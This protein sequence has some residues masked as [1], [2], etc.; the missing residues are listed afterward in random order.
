M[1]PVCAWPLTLAAATGIAAPAATM[2]HR[3]STMPAPSDPDYVYDPENW[4][5]TFEFADRDLATEDCLY[6]EP[7]K[8][9]STLV[10][11]PDIWA[12]RD[13]NGRA[14]WFST[15]EDAERFRAQAKAQEEAEEDAA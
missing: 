14:A 5:S 7:V 8:R 2:R 12:A 11:G 13:A 10:K 1:T 4:E 6:D 15:K 9:Y 3:R